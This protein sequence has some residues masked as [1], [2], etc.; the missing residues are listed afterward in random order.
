MIKSTYPC[1]VYQ[2]TNKLNGMQYIGVS[3]DP[4]RRFILHSSNAKKSAKSY[5]RDAIQKYGHSNF[6]LKVLLA[7]T[8]RYCLEMEASIIKA[9]KTVVPNGYNI[10]GG[11]EG[12]TASL[13]GDKNPM[14]GKKKTP[15]S[16]AKGASKISGELNYL[17]KE[18]EAVDPQGNVY[19]G[20]GLAQLCKKFALSAGSMSSV[21]RGERPHYKGW[22][23]KYKQPIRMVS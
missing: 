16:V 1:Y 3:K 6:S 22:T 7:G 11:G 10:C 5:I 13:Y 14:F 17:A 4:N 9:Y 8:R 20:K 12:P 23:V 21:A 15:E 19:T 2:I 18:Y